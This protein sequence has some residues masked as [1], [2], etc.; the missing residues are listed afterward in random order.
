M[1]ILIDTNI[2]VLSVQPHHPHYARIDRAF[3]I[4]RAGT[5]PLVVATQNLIEFWV[6]ATRPLGSNGLGMTPGAALQEL[7]ALK[8]L[9]SILPEPAVIYDEWERVV[10]AH[11]VSGRRCA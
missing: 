7:T 1:A 4:L 8:G 2:L 3:A 5:E 6:V 10:S 11:R 9:F